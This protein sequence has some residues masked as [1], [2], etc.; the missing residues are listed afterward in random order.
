MA[1]DLEALLELEPDVGQAF[2]PDHDR[3]VGD[4][5]ALA[6]R[7]QGVLP[8]IGIELEPAVGARDR[9]GGTRA[10]LDFRGGSYRSLR[11]GLIRVLVHDQAGHGNAGEVDVQ[12]VSLEVGNLYPARRV[13]RSPVRAL[14]Q[15]PIVAG[16]V[17]DQGERSVLARDADAPLGPGRLGGHRVEPATPGVAH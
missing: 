7:R 4:A 8:R 3:E 12:A 1:L 9:G 14:Y 10:V 5:V 2:R 13:P 11:H 17:H 16:L 6:P 15:D